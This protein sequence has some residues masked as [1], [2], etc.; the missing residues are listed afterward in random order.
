MLIQRILQLL[1]GRQRPGHAA[2]RC[3][4]LLPDFGIGLLQIVAQP[5]LEVAGEAL[6]V[7]GDLVVMGDLQ[8]DRFDLR[9]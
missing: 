2:D 6:H 4:G 7:S 9:P 1:I 8:L 3:G 5:L